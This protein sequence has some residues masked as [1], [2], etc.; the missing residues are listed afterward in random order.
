MKPNKNHECDWQHVTWDK[1]VVGPIVE[2]D[3]W[4]VEQYGTCKCGRRVCEVFVSTNEL[5]I[6]V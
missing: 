5:R 4:I 6:E 3:E 1:D 2:G